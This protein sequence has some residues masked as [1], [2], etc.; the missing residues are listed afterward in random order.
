MNDKESMKE[1]QDLEQFLCNANGIENMD[2]KKAGMK[3]RV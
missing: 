3:W 2:E 1:L